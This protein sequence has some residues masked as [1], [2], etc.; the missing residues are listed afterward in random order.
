MTVHSIKDDL[1]LISHAAKKAGEI[2][3]EFFGSKNDVWQK[4][5]N[6]PVSEADYAVDRFLKETLLN[7][8]PNYGWLSEETE[9]NADR[10]N[11]KRLFVV[12]P[13]DGTR[14]FLAG[15]K[16]WCVSVAVV[17]AQ[18]PIAGVLNCP[19][20]E[21]HFVAAKTLG[22]F[23]NGTRMQPLKN[24]D[25]QTMTGSRKLIEVM[26]ARDD[27]DYEVLPFVP[28]LA[29]RVAMVANDKLDA[30]LARPGA[31]DWDLAAADVILS[32]A[33]GKLT[34]IMGAPRLYNQPTPRSGSL[35]ASSISSHSNLVDL[36]KA[37]GFLH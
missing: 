21:E 1:D 3:F 14:G 13:I 17:E 22:A 37:G 35:I 18:S 32:E 31:H 4:H 10:L 36:A 29:Y 30:A 9:D 7:A 28:S 16:Q 34:D 19:A 26:E 15:H 25:I 8:R 12:D 11:S 6:S 5:G 27:R 33:G 20:L 24:V 23:L 2:A